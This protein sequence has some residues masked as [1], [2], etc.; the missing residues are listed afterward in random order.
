MNKLYACQATL[1]C[2]SA[3]RY[4]YMICAHLCNIYML[5]IYAIVCHVWAETF[6]FFS[7]YTSRVQGL[8]QKLA[9]FLPTVFLRVFALHLL[10]YV[11][12]I[13]HY[14]MSH[15][16]CICIFLLKIPS[17]LF[18]TSKAKRFRE[19]TV[20]SFEIPEAEG[21]PGMKQ[22][23][24]ACAWHWPAP[25]GG[26]GV[27]SSDKAFDWWV[28]LRLGIGRISSAQWRSLEL[29]VLSKNSISLLADIQTKSI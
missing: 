18:S 9:S 5:Y 8:I 16:V 19:A 13:M 6:V 14:V 24:T 3:N 7:A 26:H 20:A 25:K 11:L 17:F 22:A 15:Y 10:H 12:K 21:M 2:A 4:I 1:Q 29:Q 23:A 27:V 28:R